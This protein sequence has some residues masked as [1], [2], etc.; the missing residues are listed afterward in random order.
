VQDALDPETRRL[1]QTAAVLG[2]S[3]RMEDAATMLG[4]PAAALLA[5]ATSGRRVRVRSESP[6]ADR[7]A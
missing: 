1:L 7:P 6:G 3:F 5:A 4:T 2:R